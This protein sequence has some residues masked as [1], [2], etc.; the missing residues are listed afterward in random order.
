MPCPP[1]A[2]TAPRRAVGE[3]L[4]RP[5]S[6][7]ARLLA[8]EL[9]VSADSAYNQVVL[10]TPPGAAQFLASLSTGPTSDG[11]LGTIARL[12]HTGAGHR[13]P[14][15]GGDDL[16]RRLLALAQQP[17]A[18]TPSS[19][20]RDLSRPRPPTKEHL[21]EQGAHVAARLREGR[22]RVGWR[23][24]HLRSRRQNET[25]RRCLD[26]PPPPSASRTKAI[27]PACPAVMAVRGRVWLHRRL[28]GRPLVHAGPRRPAMRRLHHD[29][30]AR[31]TST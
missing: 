26:A 23:P 25:G 19:T 16:A 18:L 28:Q 7:L 8:G 31:R 22:H 11:V 4:A 9:L 2:A 1:R 12:G 27:C 10:R 30:R 20:S 5:A 14:P 29:G 24:R 17:R 13:P 15:A 3:S 21:R 6:R